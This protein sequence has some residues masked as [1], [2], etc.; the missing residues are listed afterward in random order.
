VRTSFGLLGAGE[1]S[2]LRLRGTVRVCGPARH[3]LVSPVVSLTSAAVVAVVK[4]RVRIRGGRASTPSFRD[5]VGW[6]RARS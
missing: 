2:P 4:P 6:R 3:D 1:T 5:G